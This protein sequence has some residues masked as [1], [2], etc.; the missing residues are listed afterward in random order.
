MVLL[1]WNQHMGRMFYN[2]PIKVFPHRKNQCFTW[3]NHQFPVA[4]RW[5][6]SRCMGTF[7]RIYIRL[8]SPWNKRMDAL[9]KL[10]PWIKSKSV[11]ASRCSC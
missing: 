11:W 9:T 10:L 1:Q 8:L 2:L 6:N 4:E 3:K 7:A 5:V